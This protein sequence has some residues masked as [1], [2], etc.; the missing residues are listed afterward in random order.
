MKPTMRHEHEESGG[1][2]FLPPLSSVRRGVGTT[3]LIEG[4]ACPAEESSDEI[5]L[6]LDA[7]RWLRIV[8]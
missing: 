2:T 7:V 6:S 4:W 1:G 5:V 8:G 3:S